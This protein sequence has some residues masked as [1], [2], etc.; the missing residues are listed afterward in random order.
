[1][2]GG[3]K[4]WRRTLQVRMPATASVT[5]SLTCNGI[6]PNLL[7]RNPPTRPLPS[8]HVAD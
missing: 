4:G 3:R 6:G 5:Y 8:A 2:A 7:T 1:M